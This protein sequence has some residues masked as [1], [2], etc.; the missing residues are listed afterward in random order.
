VRPVGPPDHPEDHQPQNEREERA[1]LE[2]GGVV[3]GA[4][5]AGGVPPDLALFLAAQQGE[6]PVRRG[7]DVGVEDVVGGRGVARVEERQVPPHGRPHA[8]LQAHHLPVA[9]R[10]GG[11]ACGEPPDRGGGADLDRGDGPALVAVRFAQ[12]RLQRAGLAAGQ[13]RRLLIAVGAVAL[14]GDG[15]HD[16]RLAPAAQDRGERQCDQRRGQRGGEPPPQPST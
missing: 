7:L 10:L 2:Q 9:P 11:V 8:L 3:L 1:H 4:F 5:E 13:I 14:L 16:R 6:D 12:Q 15:A